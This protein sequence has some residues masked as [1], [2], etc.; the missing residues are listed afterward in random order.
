[1]WGPSGGPPG[2]PPGEGWRTGGIFLKDRRSA[3]YAFGLYGVAVHEP[4]GLYYGGPPGAPS[5]GGLERLTSACTACTEFFFRKLSAP[6]HGLFPF[7][8]PPSPN[9]PLGIRRDA[10]SPPW[11]FSFCAY[12]SKSGSRRPKVG[13]VAVDVRSK[14]ENV[15]I[16]FSF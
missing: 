13:R 7:G 9:S 16:C 12:F 8:V 5:R 14:T 3:V 11:V 4:F 1:M 15:F 10:T 2:A 6:N